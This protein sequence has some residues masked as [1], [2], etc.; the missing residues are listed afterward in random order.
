VIDEMM[1]RIIIL[2]ILQKYLK[3]RILISSLF[4]FDLLMVDIS[5]LDRILFDKFTTKLM[6][7]KK[8]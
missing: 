1:I 4:E 5:L 2:K 3:K 6:N 8:Y 7:E